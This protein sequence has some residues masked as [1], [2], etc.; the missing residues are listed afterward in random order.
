[1]F[2]DDRLTGCRSET[3][4]PM[5]VDGVRVEEDVLVVV[6]QGGGA[7]QPMSSRC[8]SRAKREIETSFKYYNNGNWTCKSRLLP[9]FTNFLP[10]RLRLRLRSSRTP[11]LVSPRFADPQTNFC[12]VNRERSWRAILLIRESTA[13]LS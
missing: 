1:L 12:S 8:N 5:V 3:M 13:E 6:H 4:P 9:L 2:E 10:P 7:G 11:F